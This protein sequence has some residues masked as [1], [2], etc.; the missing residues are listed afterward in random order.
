MAR[1]QI[2]VSQEAPARRD[3]VRQVEAISAATV[4]AIAS[5][6]Q[7]QSPVRE[8]VRLVTVDGKELA[9]A[10]FDSLVDY[11]DSNGTPIVNR[12]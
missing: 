11:G 3:I 5:V 8:V 9:S 12:R 2:T 7:R 6:A 4:N 1:N 10:T